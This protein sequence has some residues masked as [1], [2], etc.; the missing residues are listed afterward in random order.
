MNLCRI[1]LCVVS[2]DAL[3]SVLKMFSHKINLDQ[4]SVRLFLHLACICLGRGFV[5]SFVVLAARRRPSSALILVTNSCRCQKFIRTYHTATRP[6]SAIA[7]P[8]EWPTT[9]LKFCT[10]L[11]AKNQ[12]QN[13]R[14][15]SSPMVDSGLGTTKP[16][17]SSKITVYLLLSVVA[18]RSNVLNESPQP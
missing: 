9:A 5:I 2:N 3:K 8:L 10:P 18:I 17:R 1:S 7:P 4:L 16:G 6:C 12:L 11:F 13:F 15:S 14:Y